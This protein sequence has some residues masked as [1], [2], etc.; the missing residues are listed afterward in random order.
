MIGGIER[1]VTGTGPIPEDQRRVVRRLELVAVEFL[2]STITNEVP[3][4]LIH[5]VVFSI[6]FQCLYSQVVFLCLV[7]VQVVDSFVA[8]GGVEKH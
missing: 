3:V 5:G 2:A 6:L 4:D 1:L 7:L 8:C